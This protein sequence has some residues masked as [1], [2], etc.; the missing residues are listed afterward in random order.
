MDNKKKNCFFYCEDYDMGQ[1]FLVAN[2]S[3]FILDAL[4]IDA[5]NISKH[6]MQS[7]S[8]RRGWTKAIYS[9]K[10]VITCRTQ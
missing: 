6:Q 2:I 7:K 10:E 4:A 8:L 3:E 1:L 9:V 5:K